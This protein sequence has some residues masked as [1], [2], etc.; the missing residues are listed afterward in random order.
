MIEL[1]TLQNIIA[2]N[3]EF[4]KGIELFRRDIATPDFANCVAV[5]LR[6]AGKSY[7][8]FQ[9]MHDF[10]KTGADWE[11]LIYINFE[12]ERL[13][14]FELAD[15]NRLLEA[16]YATRGEKSRP[17]LF[18]DEIQI[19]DGWE[20]F[21]R[22]MADEKITTFITGSNAKM[23]ST[24][25]ASLLGGRYFT[26]PITTLTFAEYLRAKGLS[27]K[28]KDLHSTKSQA[29]LFNQFMAYLHFGG[30]PETVNA[31]KE[32]ELL[33][34]ENIF[35]TIYLHAILEHSPIKHPAVLRMLLKK[36]AESVGQ[37]LSY[38]RLTN[39]LTEVNN[40]ISKVSTISYVE[41]AKEAC[42]IHAIPNYAGKLSERESVPK[43]YLADTGLLKIL[44]LDCESAQLENLVALELL[45]RFGRNDAVFYYRKNIEVD[46]YIPEEGLAIQVA[47]DLR[48]NPET[49]KREVGAIEKFSKAFPCQKR[50]ILTLEESD[51]LDSA[52]GKIEVCPI[53]KWLLSQQ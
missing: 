28:E 27:S 34:L 5:G 4:V 42:L 23:L 53:Y 8:L 16:H 11:N 47:C 15:F 3:R 25:V 43:Y 38:S 21:A 18:L 44:S 30:F 37:P 10:V 14:G 35:Q 22:R 2:D 46:F 24:D 41:L 40:K 48:K 6:R 36:I 20:K 26:I 9:V 12:S 1:S 32:N 17:I 31:K 19:I 52:V 51:T 33:S 13:I 29:R 7:W 50:L 39:L 45:R 49:V